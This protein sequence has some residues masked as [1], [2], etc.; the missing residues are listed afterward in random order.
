MEHGSVIAPS[1]PARRTAPPPPA[2]PPGCKHAFQARANLLHLLVRE[3]LRSP[4]APPD[5]SGSDG[6]SNGRASS[7]SRSSTGGTGGRSC[8][9]RSRWHGALFPYLSVLLYVDAGAAI[10]V[11]SVAMDSPDAV[12][13]SEPGDGNIVLPP[14]SPTDSAAPTSG[15]VPTFHR[16]PSTTSHTGGGREG[17]AALG[18]GV[19]RRRL[20]RG[21][22]RA[23]GGFSGARAA[24]GAVEVS[25]LG[26]GDG[27]GE[28]MTGGSRDWAEGGEGVCPSRRSI[29]EVTCWG[30]GR[31]GAYFARLVHLCF[32]VLVFGLLAP[33]RVRCTPRRVECVAPRYGPDDCT[34]NCALGSEHLLWCLVCETSGAGAMAICCY[35]LCC[36]I[37]SATYLIKTST[38]LTTHADWHARLP[39]REKQR[40][41]RPL[42][43]VTSVLAPHLSDRAEHTTAALDDATPDPDGGIQDSDDVGLSASA[44]VNGP[45]GTQPAA[46]S[47]ADDVRRSARLPT[48]D[49]DVQG[50]D[51]LKEQLVSSCLRDRDGQEWWAAARPALFDFVAKYLELSLVTVG[52]RLTNAVL[53]SVARGGWVE[54][55]PSSTAA[56]VDAQARW[57]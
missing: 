3:A 18:G 25:G 36:V 51:A 34:I 54:A 57:V 40:A 29:V 15:V 12:F 37:C 19:W 33:G 50:G 39:P 17:R 2:V 1:P 6:G 41:P 8:P 47:N 26:D 7:S 48:I 30:M 10:D 11:L 27:G 16:E 56:T 44:F 31:E 43:A 13:G 46:T 45:Q 35:L 53:V 42:Q 23:I 21:R 28:A 38:D 32:A 4:T 55:A 52:P 14:T 24:R 9:S 22:A 5:L 20:G 49:G